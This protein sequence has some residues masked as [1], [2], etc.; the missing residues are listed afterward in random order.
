MEDEHITDIETVN[1]WTDDVDEF[2]ENIRWESMFL[3]I[4]FGNIYNNLV[5]LAH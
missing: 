3:C 4:I 2:D 5:F 1:K